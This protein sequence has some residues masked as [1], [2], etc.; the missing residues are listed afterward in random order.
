MTD[1]QKTLNTTFVYDKLMSVL[2][3]SIAKIKIHKKNIEEIIDMPL[4]NARD[5]ANKL[6]N[7]ITENMTEIVWNLLNTSNKK[8]TNKFNAVLESKEYDELEKEITNQLITQYHILYHQALQDAMNQSKYEITVDKNFTTSYIF[9][10]VVINEQIIEEFVNEY[11]QDIEEISYKNL[12][13]ITEQFIFNLLEKI[14]YKILRN[15]TN[16]T[17]LFELPNTVDTTNKEYQNKYQQLKN[18]IETL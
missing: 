11:Y 17:Q 18:Y 3:N 13:K 12:D 10:S 8:N 2:I 5:I 6:F 7:N 4:S 16:S 9:F 1:I 15:N 14:I